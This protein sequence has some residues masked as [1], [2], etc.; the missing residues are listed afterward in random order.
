MTVVVGSPLFSEHHTL[1]SEVGSSY[2]TGRGKHAPFITHYYMLVSWKSELSWLLTL[3]KS[4]WGTRMGG[5]S[6]WGSQEWVGHAGKDALTSNR[7]VLMRHQ[8][9]GEW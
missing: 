8:Q 3:H 7:V 4:G 1:P 5:A 6:G 2:L 9:R